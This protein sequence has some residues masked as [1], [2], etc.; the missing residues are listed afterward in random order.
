MFRAEFRE[1]ILEVIV[2]SIVLYMRLLC[3]K[4]KHVEKI[5]DELKQTAFLQPVWAC[6]FLALS[7]EKLNRSYLYVRMSFS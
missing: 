6:S 1:I 3:W 5:I 4:G 2:I 7:E